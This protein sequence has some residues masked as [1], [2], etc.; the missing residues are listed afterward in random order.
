LPRGSSTAAASPN[1][2]SIDPRARAWREST[3]VATVPFSFAISAWAL[4]VVST[5][6]A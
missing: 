4:A 1:T 5:R 6:V 2:S 3:A